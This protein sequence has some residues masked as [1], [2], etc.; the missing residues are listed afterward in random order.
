MRT[1]KPSASFRAITGAAA[2]AL[3]GCSLAATST[4]PPATPNAAA[5]ASADPRSAPDPGYGPHPDLP[6]PNK[7]LIPT[8]KI[9]EAKGWPAGAMPTAAPRAWPSRPSPR[10]S[11]IRAGS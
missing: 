1:A 5:P 7:K 11:C 10:G 3:A 9:A 2:V 6:A 4:D 8:I